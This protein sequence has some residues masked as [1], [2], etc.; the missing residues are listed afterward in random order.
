MVIAK[1]D[2]RKQAILSGWSATLP[3]TF[4]IPQHCPEEKVMEGCAVIRPGHGSMRRSARWV[5]EAN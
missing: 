3:L 4:L 5:S 2:W 1:T